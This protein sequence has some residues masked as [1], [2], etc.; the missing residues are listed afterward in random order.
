M[1]K[2]TIAIIISTYNNPVALNEI[3]ER[4][5]AG[6]EQPEQ[7]LIADDGSGDE[8]RALVEQWKARGDLNLVHCWH[9][10]DGFRKNRIMNITLAAVTEDYMVFLDGDCLPM[11]EFVA[12]HRK[13]AE[14]GFFVQGRRAFIAESEVQK[15]LRHETGLGALFWRGK[16]S[17]LAKA[18]RFPSPVIKRN[19]EHRGL[20]GCNLAIWTKDLVAINGFDESYEGWGI[21]EDSDI[22]IRLYNMGRQRKFVYG[23]AI[24]FHL[25]HPVQNKDHVPESLKKLQETIDTKKVRCEMGLSVH[26]GEGTTA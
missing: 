19:Q 15:V 1:K 23:R 20:I 3:L 22:C 9:E 5:L 7:V 4:I 12:D 17:G 18:F 21:G 24:V 10:D 13:L 6:T 8:T 11:P 2:P 14:E 25:D 26:T 16:I